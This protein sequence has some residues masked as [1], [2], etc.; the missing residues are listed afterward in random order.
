MLLRQVL[1]RS[2]N[3]QRPLVNMRFANFSAESKEKIDFGFQ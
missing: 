3:I 1:I 2:R